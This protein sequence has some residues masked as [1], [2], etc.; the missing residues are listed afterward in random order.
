MKADYDQLSDLGKEQSAILGDYLAEIGL[1]FDKVYRGDLRRHRETE[2][3]AST[4]SKKAG[5]N[6]EVEVMPALNEHQGP[7]VVKWLL[8][9]IEAGDQSPELDSLRKLLQPIN[10]DVPKKQYLAAFEHGTLEWAKDSFDTSPIDV[11]DWKPFLLRIHT[12]LEDIMAAHPESGKTIGVFT[13]GGPVGVTIGKALALSDAQS[14][15]MNWIV[16]NSSISE[17]LYSKGRFS[18]KTFNAIPHLKEK[19]LIT[20][21]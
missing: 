11:E 1:E 15:Q 4:A 8:S 12:A 14:M 19:R 18:L 5:L 17:F 20:L 21:V 6:W 10:A 13:S 2:Q 16:Q 3:I 9:R 7:K